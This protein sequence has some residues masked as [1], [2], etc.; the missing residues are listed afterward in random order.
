MQQGEQPQTE[1]FLLSQLDQPVI[2]KEVDRQWVP[3]ASRSPSSKP[4]Q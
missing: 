3:M 2:L 4:S 1:D